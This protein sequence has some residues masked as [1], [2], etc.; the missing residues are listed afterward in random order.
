[1]SS[2]VM[3]VT[4]EAVSIWARGMREP[5]TTMVSR[6]VASSSD[7]LAA[8]PAAVSGACCARAPV[9]AASASA[10]QMAVGSSLRSM[11]CSHVLVVAPVGA[12]PR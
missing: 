4:G 8:C 6:L 1:M 3:V 9:L 5:V 11:A 7:G 2:A 10:A 12:G